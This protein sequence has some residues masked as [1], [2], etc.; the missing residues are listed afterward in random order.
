[1]L[2]Q[3]AILAPGGDLVQPSLT[4]TSMTFAAGDTYLRDR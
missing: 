2:S 3:V 4:M 1:M